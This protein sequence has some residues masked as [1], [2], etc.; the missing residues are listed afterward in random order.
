MSVSAKLRRAPL[1]I[2]T[3]AYILNSGVTKLGADDDTAK[4]L[5]GM[6][7]GTYEVIGKAE[8]K[9]FVKAVGVGEIAVGTALL[10]PIV[11]P[12]VAGAALAGFSGLL[13]NMYWNTPG[14][15][16]EGSPRPTAQGMPI[17]KDVWMFG[18]G[19]GLMADAAFEPAHDRVLELEAAV[20][21]KRGV[22]I[23]RARRRRVK[24]AA[25]A[26]K[27]ANAEYVARAR[28]GALHVKEEAAERA[29]KG[30]HRAQLASE[31]AGKKAA[32]KARKRA[33]DASSATAAR[34]AELRAEY[35]TTTLDKA[36]DKALETARAAR[37]AARH[38]A[39]EYGPVAAEKARAAQE[40]ARQAT[41]D[42]GPLAAEKARAA[43]QATREA[44]RHVAQDYG[45]V[46]AEKARAARER[47]AG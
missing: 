16:Q 40:A 39:Q 43:A 26:A 35:G 25:R 2:A 17:A 19:A 20:A 6:A 11:P 46:V 29:A 9:V 31:K 15:H 7:R 33:G 45:P 24:E 44:A 28:A 1:R 38:A 34:L 22:R 4:S 23:G 37:E 14:M 47:V 3:G 13:L 10:L 5:H 21:Q 41:Q 42:Y 32:A 30:A 12:F 18:I 8:P 36:L 27:H